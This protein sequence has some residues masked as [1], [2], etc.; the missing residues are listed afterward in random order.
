MQYFS[1]FSNLLMMKVKGK[2]TKAQITGTNIRVDVKA[3]HLFS[4]FPNS[5]QTMAN[6]SRK[7]NIPITVEKDQA[8]EVQYLIF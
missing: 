1:V 4:T 3:I 6:S 2:Q 5:T 7:R 8:M